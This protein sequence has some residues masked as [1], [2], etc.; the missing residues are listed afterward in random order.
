MIEFISLV[1]LALLA[2]CVLGLVLF[3]LW[4]IVAFACKMVLRS[5]VPLYFLIVAAVLYLSWVALTPA[6]AHEWFTGAK[7][8][9]TNARCCDGSD[10]ILIENEDW[11]ERDGLIYVKWRNGALYSIPVDQAQPSQ[12]KQGKAAACVW[13]NQLKCVFLPLGY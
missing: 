10:C 7:N 6:M 3:L 4:L 1:I 9:V 13:A 12:D 5:F 11:Y 2:G 8:P